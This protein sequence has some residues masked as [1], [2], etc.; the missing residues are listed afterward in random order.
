MENEL[1]TVAVLSY[2]SS[3][4][5]LE[6]LNSIYNQNY[7]NI[8]L[9]INDDGSDDNTK[10]IVTDWINKYKLRFYDI[11]LFFNKDNLGINKSFDYV[12]KQSKSKWL[13]F[14]AAD[15]I[16]LENCLIDNFTYV[17]DNNID[18]LL[19][20]KVISFKQEG[21]SKKYLDNDN[22]ELK[23]AMKLCSCSAEKQY[24]K[25]LKKDILFSP[26]GFINTE[27]YKETMGININI[28]NI[29]D[30]PLRLLM[31][32]SGYKIYFMNKETVMYRISESVSNSSINFYNLNHIQQ[33]KLLKKELIYPNLNKCNIFYYLNE[34]LENFRYKVVITYLS[35]RKNIVT[36]LIC[37]LTMV[38]D[39]QK[40]KK[41]IYK[42]MYRIGGYNA[43]N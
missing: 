39:I 28:K 8:A 42:V 12:L 43:G 27:L 10:E 26:S 1:I 23:Y 11:Q 36:L 18:T 15:D 41:L 13:K 31:T 2:N 24:K 30:W 22:Y 38:F 32:S 21:I 29:E 3:K 6:T 16:L 35:N 40:W 37:Y 4:T 34:Y 17:V 20:S 7:E 9:V 19:Y 25:L 5:I 14:I 33:I